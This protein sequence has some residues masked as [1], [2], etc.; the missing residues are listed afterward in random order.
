MRT[1]EI[2]QRLGVRAGDRVWSP[3][4]EDRAGIRLDEA[5]PCRHFLLLLSCA[6]FMLYCEVLGILASG[7]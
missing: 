5:R 6:V 2:H 7:A 4:A 1:L 3:L